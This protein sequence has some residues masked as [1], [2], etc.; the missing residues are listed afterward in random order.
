MSNTAAKSGFGTL[1]KIGDGGGSEVF[2]TIAEIKQ[3]Q[4][5]K[6]KA[7]TFDATNMGSPTNS[8]GTAGFR[9]FIAGLIDAGEVQITGNY[10]SVASQDSLR[11]TH[12]NGTLRNFQL[13]VPLA[14]PETW[15]FAAVVTSL[16]I[17]LPHDGLM[18][19]AATLKMS[20]V[21]TI[22]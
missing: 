14:V 1:L 18:A 11:T 12:W 2:T 5:P 21:P 16:D 15:S 4:G 20:G 19:F 13:V 17:T 9:E 22:A 10:T 8:G 7:D 3:I 6:S